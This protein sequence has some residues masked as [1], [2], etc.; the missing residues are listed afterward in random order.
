M[1]DPWGN[2]FALIV[3]PGLLFALLAAMIVVMR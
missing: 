1:T 3:L 2:F